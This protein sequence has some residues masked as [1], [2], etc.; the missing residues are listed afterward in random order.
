MKRFEAAFARWV[1]ANRWLV[2][3]VSLA[4]VA[5]LTGGVGRLYFDS[6]YRV[7][8]SKDNPQLMAFETLERTYTKNDNV[9]FV[10]EPASGDVFTRETLAA[11]EELTT[12][13]WQVPYSNR[14]DSIT[15]FQYTEAEEDDLI[16]RDM[17]KDALSLD[18]QRLADIKRAVLAEPALNKRLVNDRG[19]VTAIYV[20]V[21]MPE[22]ERTT[23]TP[24]IVEAAR[25]MARTFERDHPDIKVHL[26]G[27][28]LMDN[29]FS[30]SGMYDSMYLVPLSFVLMLAIIAVLV[31]GSFGTFATLFV[32][33]SSIACGLG[34]AGYVGFPMTSVTTSAPIIILTVAVANCVHLLTTFLHNMRD[35]AP[36]AR[37]MEESLRI[38][39]QPVFLASITTA[40]GFLTMNFS[41]VP[42]FNHLGNIVS[43]GVV[44]SFFLTIGFLPAFMTLVPVRAGAAREDDARGMARLADF[45]I[46]HRRGLLWGS[47]VVVLATVANL[48]RNQLNDV[49]VHYFGKSIQFRADTDFM[50]DNLTGIYT[51][52]YSLESG[53]SGGIAEPG[54]LAD[55]EAFAEWFEQQ[56]DVIHVDRFTTIMKR[57]NKNMHG[58]DS[59][60]YVLPDDRELAAQYLLLY[61]MSLPY[62]LDLNNQINVDKSSTRLT[63]T[64]PVI[65][66]NAMIALD[67]RAM[68]WASANLR[69]VERV[70]SAGTTL[71]FS[72]IGHR[73]IRSM[74]IG[75]TVALVLISGILM[76]A[77][78]SFRLGSVSLLPNLAPAAMGFGL[79]GI[80]VGEVGLSL[81]VVTGMTFGIVID[82]TVHFLSKYLRAR[83]EQGLDPEAAV[84]YAF[85]TVGRALIITTVTLVVGF[86]VLSTSSFAINS[87]M[88]LMTAIIIFIALIGVFLMLPPL[89]MKIEEKDIHASSDDGTVDRAAAA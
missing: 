10:L 33:G 70:D 43:V 58:D 39:L 37:A 69:R 49:F 40:I 61:E 24:V 28:V 87:R 42:P 25:E 74:L 44:V 78:R 34:A 73:N 66:S 57:L 62:G 27:M 13:A 17:V 32:I 2:I 45:V 15:N 23:A 11:V 63:V 56:P 71:M 3:L 19:H 67:E 80:F 12:A 41:D 20:T 36:R 76:L 55:V 81:S 38:N 84:R 83:R 86:A 26:T 54:F 7:F 16:V 29:A 53:Q 46:A 4:L 18:D 1:I 64:L 77:L 59:E 68:A 89:L 50:V 88:G 48:P 65:S 72:H 75:T 31:G 47:F 22:G 82:D 14:V 51:I 21:Q 6:S 52:S 35:G 85:R 60:F 8:F 5:A 9:L 30:E 79:W